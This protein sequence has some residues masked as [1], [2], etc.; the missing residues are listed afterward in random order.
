MNKKEPFILLRHESTNIYVIAG[1]WCDV[2]ALRV[3][4]DLGLHTSVNA[5][6]DERTNVTVV[7]EYVNRKNVTPL[8][9]NSES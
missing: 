1:K 5:E 9:S 3:V 6:Y 4:L 7:T 8:M 2:P